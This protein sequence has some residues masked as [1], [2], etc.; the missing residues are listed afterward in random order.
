[1]VG[2]SSTNACRVTSDRNGES[3]SSAP[4]PLLRLECNTLAGA[5]GWF[6]FDGDPKSEVG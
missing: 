2:E 1:M 4:K 6:P 5:L 3:V